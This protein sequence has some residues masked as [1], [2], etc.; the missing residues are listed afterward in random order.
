MVEGLFYGGRENGGFLMNISRIFVMLLMCSAALSELPAALTVPRHL[1]S[2][3]QEAEVGEHILGKLYVALGE[4]PNLLLADNW[5]CRRGFLLKA[6][7][8]AVEASNNKNTKDEN[9]Q[10][11]FIHECTMHLVQ[12]VRDLSD[13]DRLLCLNYQDD[14]DDETKVFPTDFTKEPVPCFRPSNKKERALLKKYGIKEWSGRSALYLEVSSESSKACLEAAKEIYTLR[15]GKNKRFQL[16]E[17]VRI[18]S[19]LTS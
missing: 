16:P 2:V 4:E 7:E 10:C 12:F 13:V 6:F 11:T 19:R 9:H 5:H 17:R 15:L 18:G 8:D 14:R 3:R 1:A